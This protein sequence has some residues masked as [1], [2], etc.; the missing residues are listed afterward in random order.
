MGEGTRLRV[1]GRRSRGR[2][3]KYLRPFTAGPICARLDRPPEGSVV[4]AAIASVIDR[5]VEADPSPGVSITIETSPIG[6]EADPIRL[7]DAFDLARSRIGEFG[8][9]PDVVLAG[10]ADL[11]S[12]AGFWSRRTEGL[13]IY[14]A[15]GVAEVVDLDHAPKPITRVGRSFRLGPLLRMLPWSDHLVL[16]LSLKAPRVFKVGRRTAEELAVRDMPEGIDEVTRFEDGSPSLQSHAAATVGGGK[17]VAAFHGQ[18][19]EPRFLDDMRSHYLREIDAAVTALGDCSLILAGVDELVAEF[20]R[21]SE[22]PRLVEAHISGNF[23]RA[24]ASEIGDLARPLTDFNRRRESDLAEIEQRRRPVVEGQA[25]VAEA[26][27]TGRVEV[28]LIGPKADA[29]SIATEV[30]RHGGRIWMMSEPPGEGS[31]AA[32]LR[33]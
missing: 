33:Y 28:L 1:G 22:H 25:E 10:V 31:L 32:L 9:D 12:E 26:A 20:R 16:S 29:D 19:G 7:R 23:D 3:D 30:W 8:A 18:G 5:L 21:L 6:S 15:K 11:G 24:G 17:T 27:V 13:A 4:D 14:A 2:P